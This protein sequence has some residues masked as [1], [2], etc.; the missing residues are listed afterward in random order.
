MKKIVNLI[1]VYLYT[2]PFIVVCMV[3]WDAV[4]VLPISIC[5]MF[6]AGYY[7]AT[8][9]PERPAARDILPNRYPITPMVLFV[10]L[11][12]YVVARIF[13]A[14]TVVRNLID[15]RFVEAAVEGAALR[16]EGYDF[17]SWGD[18]IA[19]SSC[20]AYA[21]TLGMIGRRKLYYYLILLGMFFIESS[22]LAR[23]SVLLATTAFFVE[24]IIKESKYLS[25]KSYLQ[26]H[27]FIAA[28]GVILLGIFTFSAYYR[29]SGDDDAINIVFIE[30]LP[31]YTIGAH[32]IFARWMTDYAS[33][34]WSFGYFTFAWIF[35]IFSGE[36]NTGVQGAYESIYTPFGESNIYTYLR[37]LITDFGVV[38][39]YLF[40][41][42]IGF[43]ARLFDNR[44]MGWKSYFAL[45]VSM[46]M[47]LY[48]V[49]SPYYFVVSTVGFM[50]P[51]FLCL[52]REYHLA[53][54]EP[55]AGR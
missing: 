33:E 53:A 6:Y 13:D 39:A 28:A 30:K 37:G 23:S 19:T 48:F 34:A 29:V 54:R 50:F 5:I 47:Y 25:S 12:I 36:F 2:I 15:G 24:Y 45:R 42:Y 52:F 49:I 7:I 27:Y 46:W 18:K 17:S 40:F 3:D 55:Q 8:L 10:P 44:R 32:D 1:N 14:Q 38:S 26:L 16:Y 31:Q 20:I 43:S 9:A 21:T 51:F 4:S 35:K 22:A 11:A 41:F